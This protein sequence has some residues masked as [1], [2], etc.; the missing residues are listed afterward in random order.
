MLSAESEAAPL[1]DIGEAEEAEE[2]RNHQDSKG[3]GIR[4]AERHL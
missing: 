1:G 3:Q 4:D 2:H